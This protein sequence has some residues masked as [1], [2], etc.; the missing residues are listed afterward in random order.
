ML[1]YSTAREA[2]AKTVPR[3]RGWRAI[4]RWMTI[5][6]ILMSPTLASAQSVS[7]S[8]S[9]SE[10]FTNMPVTL[11]V[12]TRDVNS[13]LVGGG[14]FSWSLSCNG[15]LGSF[16][17]GPP[18]VP[19][20]DGITDVSV[21]A[22]GPD[23]CQLSVFWDDD[24]NIATSP[25][26]P[27]EP[28]FIVIDAVYSVANPVGP[29]ASV[30][31]TENPSF[32]V[33]ILVDGVPGEADTEWEVIGPS[34][35]TFHGGQCTGDYLSNPST[36]LASFD[37]ASAIPALTPMTPG[38]YT[39]NVR[40]YDPFACRKA[41][42]GKGAVFAPPLH[43]FTLT[44]STFSLAVVSPPGNSDVAV[45]QPTTI[46]V[47]VR[48]GSGV[49]QPGY[50]I[51]YS[52]SDVNGPIGSGSTAPS[53]G[54]GQATF[55]ITPTAQGGVG[56]STS[57]AIDST[58]IG[59]LMLQA[60]D[61]YTFTVTQPLGGAITL[62]P[63]TPANFTMTVDD[64]G[65]NPAGGQNIN[66][67]S[68]PPIAGLPTSIQTSTG[69]PDPLGQASL[70][71]TTPPAPGDYTITVTH[72]GPFIILKGG[73]A[74]AT[75]FTPLTEQILLTVQNLII[76][77]PDNFSG[78]PFAA[79]GGSTASV[80]ANDS[81]NGGPLPD[82]AV[83]STITNNDGLAGL[84]INSLG[85]LTVPA[86]STAGTYNPSYQV[87][88]NSAPANCSSSTAT[89]V[90][91]ASTLTEIAGSNQGTP[92]NTVFPTTF[93]VEARDGGAT[94]AAPV[95]IDWTV[96]NGTPAAT[97]TSTDANGIA[98]LVVTAGG[99]GG[100]VTVTAT[101]ADKPTATVTFSNVLAQ[102]PGLTPAIVPSTAS[103]SAP[104]AIDYTISAQNSGTQPLTAVQVNVTLPGGGAA[105]LTGPAGDAGTP[106]TLDVGETWNYTT[107]YPATQADIDAGTPLLADLQVITAEFPNGLTAQASTGI[108][109]TATLTVTKNAALSTDDGTTGLADAGDVITYNVSAQNTGNVTLSGL[110]VS[111][112]FEGGA[113]VALACSPTT[114][115]PGIT[116]NCSPY[117][118]SVTQAEVDAGGTLDNNV[119]ASATDPGS[120]SVNASDTASVS[121]A[122]QAAQ[123]TLTKTAILS[124]DNGAAGQADVGDV[125]TYTVAVQNTGNVSFVGFSVTDSFEGGAA[126][127]LGCPSTAL[128][129]GATATC[130]TYTH[131]VTQ[132]DA[133]AGGSL[134][135]TAT[136][137][138]TYNAPIPANSTKGVLP[139]VTS[140]DTASVPLAP[141]A[142]V[143]TLAA[144]SGDGQSGEVGT[145]LPLPLRVVAENDAVPQPGVSITWTV[146]PNATLRTLGGQTGQSVSVLTGPDGTAQV[147]LI[148]GSTPGSISISAARDD[149][150]GTT[151]G[152]VATATAASVVFDL[153]R[154]TSGS[155]DGTTAAPGAR[156]LLGALA[157]R[158][159]APQP[160]VDVIWTSL[161]AAG[162]VTPAIATTGADGVAR[163]GL[164]LAADGSGPVRVQ[165]QRADGLGSGLTYTIT[166]AGQP[167]ELL[168]IVSGDG[169]SGAPGAS[170][171]DLVVRYTRGGTPVAGA[172]VVWR[173]SNGDAILTPPTTVTTDDD[174][175]ARVGLRLGDNLGDSTIIASTGNASANFTVTAAEATAV[176]LRLVSGNAQRG[177]VGTQADEPVVVQTLQIGDQGE[178]PV[179]GQEVLW[180]IVS[181]PATFAGGA[182][183]SRTVSSIDGRT[184]LPFFFGST[185]GAI[186]IQVHL[187]GSSTV[188][189]VQATAF[190]P[191][192]RIVSGDG[193]RGPTD[194]ELAMPL[195]VGIGDPGANKTLAGSTVRWRV[196]S[197]GGQLGAASTSTTADGLS[198]N[199]LRLGSAQGDN[200]V[201]A[202]V[203]DATVQFT[204]IAGVDAGASFTIVSGNGQ[205]LATNEN[206]AP[207]V[208]QLLDAAGVP[209][210][211]ARVL[212]SGEN[213][214][215][216]DDV[217][218]TGVDGRA[219]TTAVLFDATG[220]TI[221][222]ALEGAN[223]EL[224][225]ALNG[226]VVETAGLD[227]DQMRNAALIDALCPALNQLHEQGVALNDGEADLLARCL[228]IEDSAGPRPQEVQD[229]LGELVTRIA[230][231][232]SQSALDTLR[233]QLGNHAQR[234]DQLR[235]G[236]R[237]GLAQNLGIGLMTSQGLVSLN[238]LPSSLTQ[239]ENEGEGGGEVGLD[240]D[241][242]GFFATGTI[243][244]GESR[245]DS[246]TADYDF[247]TS[248]LTAGVDYRFNDRVVAGLSLGY[249]KHDT[250]L[251][252][253][254]GNLDTSGWAVSGYAT[255]FNEANWFVD[256]VLSYGSNSYDMLRRIRYD[257]TALDGGRT[258]VDQVAR[259][260]TD[261]SQ[262]GA[263]LS[264][265]RDFQKGAWNFST[266]LRGD[267][268]RISFD[269]Y[270]ERAVAGSDGEGLVLTVDPRDLTSSAA[271]LGGKATYI[272]SRDWGILMPHVQLELQQE[273]EDDPQRLVT[274][275]T[276]DPT[277]TAALFE[278]QEVDSSLYNL[279]LGLSALFPG[280][281]SAYIYYERL[282]GSSQIKQDTL[283]VGVRIE[284]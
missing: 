38:V 165:A 252:N 192:L 238:L 208:V 95:N 272:M 245:P 100:P 2:V 214:A 109:Q 20:V 253:D 51:D 92:I 13:A 113:P 29:P 209:I 48:D 283:S 99:T 148:L 145:T 264:V 130:P 78:T 126:V 186:V 280:G 79:S 154:P 211:G 266:Y 273:F 201:E 244:R 102:A 59:N 61:I 17:S 156:V 44:A 14:N 41:R 196:L 176:L 249:A 212:W 269:G 1:T 255:W 123:V 28:A 236:A 114:L 62:P 191:T 121:V 202:A 230:T 7:F 104:G 263:S 94:P 106:G 180:Q 215:P 118:H 164:Q 120:S 139:S 175:L 69:S 72:T 49:A 242:W 142:V 30:H 132:V 216:A 84:G 111:D 158:N 210:R 138:A 46:T 22:S 159:G 75:G 66:V 197:G 86:L 5:L 77:N 147:E 184:S 258:V 140:S 261:S 11:Q 217:T 68:A 53:D 58:V 105:T 97:T 187:N 181:G 206:S 146:G 103:I 207:L 152:F 18:S 271:T 168:E 204:A 278:G 277:Q 108:A 213:A 188:V 70:A 57:L 67:S 101:R 194:S 117:T 257:I 45:G 172:S 37:F 34:G 12:E 31:L 39:V 52:A 8:S 129:P 199:T 240:F 157:T 83:T 50:V 231:V 96:S 198:Q 151:V 262:V 183:S 6:A 127:A 133:Q 32:S 47:E 131:T 88:E 177:P 166:I 43:Q 226:G 234:F 27:G 35:T 56:V 232:L 135:N 36:G 76:A 284:F 81:Y 275:F 178:E 42:G 195:V 112:V 220:G 167:T 4:T 267:Y 227:G 110:S 218:V 149:A 163:T 223:F 107:S 237:G 19:D 143:R 54:A 190:A 250:E 173:V 265:G 16:V 124:T 89:V 162:T 221:T 87:C 243:G 63:N 26:S 235:R 10:T 281:K 219:Q 233:T 71:F 60:K 282:M 73:A 136:V 64:A 141:L 74:K 90:V 119:S 137:T 256:G 153:V 40:A 169:Q 182:T 91:V 260:D 205:R 193:Q 170:L 189:A 144:V 161:D 128:A 247:D 155:G 150:P 122:A 9:F 228:E 251:A 225:F 200:V 55:Q 222:A 254:A 82:T 241:R 270:S 246:R 85:Q 279:G 25:F 3:N 21:V 203:G 125:I 171:S 24:D 224:A 276:F 229:A 116:A 268:G 239:N 179:S 185:P 33:N 93:Q 174:G 23:F 98:T 115:A 160:G 15:G 65:G 259:A 134:D 80:Y 248:G 274:R